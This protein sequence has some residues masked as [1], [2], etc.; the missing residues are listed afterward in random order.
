MKLFNWH[1]K[2][3]WKSGNHELTSYYNLLEDEFLSWKLDTSET[4]ISW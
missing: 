1:I 3:A 2:N 4:G